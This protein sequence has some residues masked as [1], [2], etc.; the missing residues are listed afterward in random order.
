VNG[1]QLFEV[2]A[3]RFGGHRHHLGRQGQIG[4]EVLHPEH[5]PLGAVPVG[6]IRDGC[7]PVDA[8]SAHRL[9][10]L[11][12]PEHAPIPPSVYESLTYRCI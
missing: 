9:E 1:S 10:P 4:V 2:A 6:R 5:R 7:H 3:V 11:G 12:A 8:E